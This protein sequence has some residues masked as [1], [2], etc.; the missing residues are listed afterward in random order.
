MS[1]H[2]IGIMGAEMQEV[3]GIIN[4]LENYTTTNIGM[5]EY[6]SGK[7]FGKDVVVTVS[8]AGKVAAATTVSALIHEFDITS[9]IFTGVAGALHPD[10]H[11]GDVVIGE[12]LVQYDVDVRP[13]R[14]QF[15]IPILG[16]T[17]F[18]SDQALVDRAKEAVNHLLEKEIHD[19]LPQAIIEQFSLYRPKL[20]SGLIGSGDQFIASKEKRDKISAL[21][22]DCLCVEMEGAAVAQICYEYEIPF[23]II[24]TISDEASEGADMDFAAF[25]EQVSIQYSVEIV[26]AM[27]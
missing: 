23:V 16:I 3:D 14:P 10:L 17:Y 22:P 13:F 12:Q 2:V 4:L 6:Y 7:L 1:N 19:I 26:K 24:R 18:D 9:L 5:R 11:V 8:R 15:E 21:L 27:L 25:L 20:H